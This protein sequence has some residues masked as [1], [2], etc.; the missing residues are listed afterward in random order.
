M[1]SNKSVSDADLEH[2]YGL[3]NL[4]GITLG[5]TGVTVEGLAKL[6][7]ALPECRVRSDFTD[8]QIA[9]ATKGL[10]TTDRLFPTSLVAHPAKL[11][12]VQ[13]LVDRNAGAAGTHVLV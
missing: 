2:L 13:V 10:N 3:K 5:D 4:K 12:G 11:P 1:T 9:A 7:A 8:E 6:K